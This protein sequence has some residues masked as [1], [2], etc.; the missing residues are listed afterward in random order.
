M[1]QQPYS[2]VN[3]Q[4]GAVLSLAS[5]SV[6]SGG[7]G[8][9]VNS[10]AKGLT[11][12]LY[13]ETLQGTSPSISATVQGYDPITG[14]AFNLLNGPTVSAAGT[15]YMQVYPGIATASGVAA[16]AVLPAGVEIVY[17]LG[18]TSPTVSAT[19]TANFQV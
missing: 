18:G 13:V 2:P 9:L 1:P 8:A 5:S 10:Q 3:T 4:L 15:H 7:T 11:A 6:T 19:V 17:S 12:V 14:Q 16:N